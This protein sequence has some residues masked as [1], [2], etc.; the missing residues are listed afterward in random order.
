MHDNSQQ[1]TG[2]QK[3]GGLPEGYH[4]TLSLERLVQSWEEVKCGK[5]V[6]MFPRFTAC[7]ETAE[8]QQA[9][10][11]QWLVGR[12]LSIEIQITVC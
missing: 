5:Q 9:R 10:C 3:N 12:Q 6:G 2:P 7:L 4:E 11:G 8:G 1:R